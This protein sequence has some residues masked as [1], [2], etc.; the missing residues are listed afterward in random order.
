MRCIGW[1]FL[2][3]AGLAAAAPQQATPR[4]I[5]YDLNDQGVDASA[6]GDFAVA[7]RLL[8]QAIEHW[9]PMGP[10]YDGHVATALYNKAEAQCGEGKWR[11]ASRNFEESVT[12]IKRSRGLRNDRTIHYENALANVYMMLGEPGKAE[13]VFNEILPVERQLFPASPETAR[14]LAGVSSLYARAGRLDEAI[15]PAEEALRISIEARG[16]K[17]PETAMMYGQVAQVLT[18]Q[19][20]TERSLPL[21]RKARAIFEETLGPWTSRISMLLS[22]EALALI[23]DGKLATAEKNLKEAIKGLSTC[24]G[25]GLELAVARNHLAM[26]RM[27]QHKFNEADAILTQAIADEEA[28]SSRPGSEMASTLELLSQVR[29]MEQRFDDAVQLQKRAQFIRGY[30]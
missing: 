20:H 17:H 2:L 9:R 19:G 8:D 3:A 1:G 5:G 22:Q 13:A 14:T 12:L 21:F 18:L 24:A 11:E 16:E 10:D 7:E 30:R 25:C 15:A 27:S 4:D 26:V 23:K 29:K 28:F 6:R